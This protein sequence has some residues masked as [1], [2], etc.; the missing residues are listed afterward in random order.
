MSTFSTFGGS[1]RKPRQ[2]NLSGR[3]ANP[4][5]TIGSGFGSQEVVA[6]AQQE[7]EKRHREGE[8]LKAARTIQRS[9]RRHSNQKATNV[10]LRREFDDT[11]GETGYSKTD[12]QDVQAYASAFQAYRQ[13]LLLHRFFDS[14][15]IEDLSRLQ[16]CMSRRYQTRKRYIEGSLSIREERSSAIESNKPEKHVTISPTLSVNA[17]YADLQKR[18]ILMLDRATSTKNKDSSA[19][20]DHIKYII[21]SF[22]LVSARIPKETALNA[23]QIYSALAKLVS[24]MPGSIF[25]CKDS[26]LVIRKMWSCPI[27]NT[28][29][30]THEN[31]GGDNLLG[32][33]VEEDAF[34]TDRAP[35]ESLDG[36]VVMAEDHVEQFHGNTSTLTIP[37]ELL[38]AYLYN[39]RPLLRLLEHLSGNSNSSAGLDLEWS[40]QQLASTIDFST[41]I[42]AL[43]KSANSHFQ[44]LS[45]VLF[46]GG[47]VRLA[48][49]LVYFQQKYY[50]RITVDAADLPYQQYLRV[51]SKLLSSLS[52]RVNMDSVDDEVPLEPFLRKQLWLL[53]RDDHLKSLLSRMSSLHA[54]AAEVAS[55]HVLALLKFFPQQADEIRMKLCLQAAR[56]KTKDGQIYSIPALAWF[57]QASLS[58]GSDDRIVSQIQSHP[59]AAVRLLNDSSGRSQDG[60]RIILCFLE[61]Y[62]FITKVTDDDEF[63]AGNNN[64]SYKTLPLQDIRQLSKFLMNLGFAM[65]FYAS[66][67]LGGG[68]RPDVEGLRARFSSIRAGQSS[69]DDQLVSTQ[70]IAVGG[71]EIEYFKNVV[72]GLLSMLYQR[73]SRRK[74]LEDGFWLMTSHLDMGGFTDAVVA[75]EERRREAELHESD[76]E[77]EE[78]EAESFHWTSNSRQSTRRQAKSRN[79]ALVHTYMANVAPRLEI[80][81]H[82]PFMIMFPVRLQIFRQFVHGDKVCTNLLPFLRS[83]ADFL[84]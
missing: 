41:F 58:A 45:D 15:N 54:N 26:F 74:F 68:T 47:R 11:E 53:R 75:E 30:K 17:L 59:H 69:T 50:K 63:L 73:D 49:T 76:S 2:V 80:L 81:R 83:E 1:S 36:D 70:M 65:S 14:R 72:T 23:D 7:R 9:W 28:T 71:V 29:Y 25:C 66:E 78:D 55:L 40:L 34:N 43:D 62:T 24:L 12:I 84:Q 18:L 10:Q 79:R 33:G 67:I 51:V 46:P 48:A 32:L 64:M 82:M 31:T 57:W 8:R 19:W 52:P 77:D 56:G 4:F 27:A 39:T 61:L 20:F 35:S 3:K 5:A 22:A 60:W 37:S 21:D 16:R 13:L 44:D 6:K 38:Q 42:A